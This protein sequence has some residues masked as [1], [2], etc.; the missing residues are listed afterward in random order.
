MLRVLLDHC[1]PRYLKFE[2]SGHTAQTA[3]EARLDDVKDRELLA[4][5][6]GQLNSRFRH[7]T[8][9]I[10][11]LDPGIH[12]ATNSGLSELRNGSWAQGPG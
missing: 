11:G 6:D 4:A 10:P 8:T 2:L 12:R 9:V 5:I 7:P 1:I 3:R